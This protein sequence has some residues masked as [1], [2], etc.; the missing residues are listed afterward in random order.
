MLSYDEMYYNGAGLGKL[1]AGDELIWCSGSS[2]PEPSLYSRINY[3]QSTNRQ[4][5]NT[6]YVPNE[7]MRVEGVFMMF[8][9]YSQN[10]ATG[11]LQ[12]PFGTID[13]FYFQ[14]QYSS[15]SPI[16]R[17]HCGNKT[18][19][20]PIITPYSEK[21]R[22]VADI[23]GVTVYRMDGSIL[24]SIPITDA[25]LSDSR[26][27][28]I[29]SK[30]SPTTEDSYTDGRIYSFKIYENDV[31]IKDFV[32]ARRNT[33]GVCGMLD[34]I[35]GEFY[36]DANPNPV[37]FFS[38]DFDENY[39][40]L[41]AVETSGDLYVDTGY[42]HN[43]NTRITIDSIPDITDESVTALDS[44]LFGSNYNQSYSSD[45]WVL[46]YRTLLSGG[47]PAF[48]R[49]ADVL[50][51]ADC[52]SMNFRT[53]STI[54]AEGLT[55]TMTYPDETQVSI[56]QTDGVLN[57][58]VNTMYLFWENINPDTGLA[59]QKAYTRFYSAK[60]S[61]IQNG[62]E[63]VIRDL[64][65]VKRNSDLIITLYDRISTAEFGGIGGTFTEVSE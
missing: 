37:G 10:V 36:V 33:D 18:Q 49:G 63:T 50:K 52:S 30:N 9:N 38:D 6:G 13:N 25:T 29:F 35:S 7:N 22:I 24:G 3:I 42:V 56:T 21:I 64:I 34:E 2:S 51:F 55:M 62:T 26:P 1:F 39:S 16:S 8:S 32:P 46:W 20:V 4:T 47:V 17:F 61:E 59:Y 54:V 19:S 40:V 12:A 57:S 65:P 5:I 15:G 43:Q 53:R 58:G 44:V 41:D 60:I 23:T 28:F 45:M 11:Y 48:R 14:N 31:L 27:L